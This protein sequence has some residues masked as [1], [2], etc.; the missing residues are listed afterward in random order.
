MPDATT[1]MS[2]FAAAMTCGVLLA[3]TAHMLSGHLGLAPSTVWLEL[4]PTEAHAVRAALGWWLI[5]AAGLFGSFVGGLLARPRPHP[6]GRAWRWLL[7]IPFFLLLAAVPF[8]AAKTPAPPLIALATNLAVFALALFTAFCG[9]W[10]ASRT[11][12]R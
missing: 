7:A 9:S 2:T 11:L 10:F 3:L 6:A 4:F 8:L 12:Q 5:A 1:S